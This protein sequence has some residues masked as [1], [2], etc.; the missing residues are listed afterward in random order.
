MRVSC[1][2]DTMIGERRG[3]IICW[4]MVDSTRAIRQDFDNTNTYLNVISQ[5]VTMLALN[6][7]AELLQAVGDGQIW[8]LPHGT[9]KDRA[10]HFANQILASARE[11]RPNY[12]NYLIKVA[13]G[14]GTIVDS[15]LG[16][17]GPVI[18]QIN[19]TMKHTRRQTLR[20][21]RQ[22]NTIK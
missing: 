2:I 6:Y 22:K 11:H 4:D 5:S 13:I 7:R 18:W 20:L 15:E 21:I 9:K 16:P 1:I 14:H 12:P 17:T 3:Y 10:E 8:L 19:Y